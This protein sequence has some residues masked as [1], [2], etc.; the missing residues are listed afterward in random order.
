MFFQKRIQHREQNLLNYNI[1]I[2]F[3]TNVSTIY[4][5]E[6]WIPIFNLL[7]SNKKII[8]ITRQ[9]STYDWMMKHTDY[10]IRYCCELDDLIDTYESSSLKC[11]LY[12]NHGVRNF[13]S[14]MYRNALHI[15]IN[16][17]ESEKVSTISNQVNAYNYV[18][19]V[20]NA[21]LDKYR[22]NL[23]QVDES[24]FIQIGRPQLEHIQNIDI[25]LP[26][27]RKII[28][29]APTWEGTHTS[30]NYTSLDEYGMKII[31]TILS[32]PEYY[33]IYKPHP[34][35]GSRHTSTKNI[36]KAI[37]KLLNSHKNGSVVQSG[38]INSLFKYTDIAIIDNSAVAID[39][40][41]IDK[42]ML[43]VDMFHRAKDRQYPPTIGCAVHL[44]SSSNINQL[45][46]IIDTN[47]EKDALQLAR[48]KVKKYFL[49]NYTYTNKESTTL[50]LTSI[51]NICKERDILI[52]KLQKIDKEVCLNDV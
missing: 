46:S 50:F 38:N 1:A 10:N 13:Q 52:D 4:Q 47:I 31:H 32:A 45:I 26:K 29:Y 27:D 42:P 24:K 3:G 15:H 2:Y 16:H 33:L 25:Q 22:Y 49:G 48:D 36:N 7:N 9:V 11:I 40:L 23:L 37:V 43:M 28:L 20:G 12:V 14:L 44:L 18:F 30:M 35:T 17:G 21:A 51:S 8:V 39:Y 6:Q 41:Q 34:N 19:I 5:F